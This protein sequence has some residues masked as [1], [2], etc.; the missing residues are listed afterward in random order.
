MH[1]SARTKIFITIVVVAIIIGAIIYTIII[2][3]MSDIKKISATITD[4]KV[5]LER[6]YRRGQLLRKTVENFERVKPRK[7]RLTSIFMRQGEELDFITTL[8]Q[9]AEKNRL[10]QKIRLQIDNPADRVIPLGLV[11]QGSYNQIMNYLADLEKLDF[12]YN[13]S[14]L[15]L[16]ASGPIDSL[17]RS[18][19]TTL[20]GQIFAISPNEVE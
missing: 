1:L 2:P 6:K 4:Q 12:Y 14:A 13:V 18:I 5:D 3:V 8:E 20:T 10:D 11:V 17:G 9:I 16:T 7:E 19:A 15:S